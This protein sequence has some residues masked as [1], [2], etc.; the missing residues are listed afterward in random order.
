[1]SHYPPIEIP[2]HGEERFEHMRPASNSA[3]VFFHGHSHQAHTH[4]PLPGGAVAISVGVDANNYTPVSIDN[5]AE[6]TPQD[7][8]LIWQLATA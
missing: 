8:E 2:D 7:R 4:T 5:I 3:R 1:M 6:L